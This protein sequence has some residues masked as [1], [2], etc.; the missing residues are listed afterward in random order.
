MANFL[1]HGMVCKTTLRRANKVYILI[2]MALICV[3]SEVKKWRIFNECIVESPAFV[4]FIK[5]VKFIGKHMYNRYA[6]L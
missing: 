5:K 2:A 6:I 1:L 3:D 4:K